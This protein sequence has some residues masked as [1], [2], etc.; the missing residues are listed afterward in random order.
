MK[1]L[2]SCSEL[3]SLSALCT[4]TTNYSLPHIPSLFEII[5]TGEQFDRPAK[6]MGVVVAFAVE[7]YTVL[8]LVLTHVSESGY[9]GDR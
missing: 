2:H 3:D 8:C 9:N 5:R 1:T 7:L 4:E 6:L